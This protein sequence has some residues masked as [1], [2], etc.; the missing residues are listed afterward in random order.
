MYRI[1]MTH[2]LIVRYF[3]GEKSRKKFRAWSHYKEADPYNYITKNYPESYNSGGRYDLLC[4][5][6]AKRMAGKL[7]AAGVKNEYYVG[8]KPG[9]DHCYVLRLPFGF[10][11]D[12]M[13][14]LLE[15]YYRNEKELG[16]DM[17][18]GW[19]KVKHF[20][21]NYEEDLKG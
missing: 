10:A 21:E 18:E 14:K 13:K 15:W 9:S 11:R 20:L 4:L 17:T 12:D 19:T 3:S 2:T 6:E 16:A 1:P 7:T 5:G 8:Q